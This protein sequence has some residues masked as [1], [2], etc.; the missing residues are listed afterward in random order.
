[1]AFNFILDNN[2]TLGAIRYGTFNFNLEANK[3]L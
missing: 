2:T 1:M 3:I